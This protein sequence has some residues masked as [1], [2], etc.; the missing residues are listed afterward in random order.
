MKS[1]TLEVKYGNKRAMDMYINL[2]FSIKLEGKKSIM[3]GLEL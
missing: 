3:M 1:I 2:G